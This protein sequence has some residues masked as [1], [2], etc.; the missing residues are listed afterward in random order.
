M[1]ERAAHTCPVSKSLH[2]DLKQKVE[3]IWQK[4]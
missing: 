4:I 3:F 2:P 1:Y